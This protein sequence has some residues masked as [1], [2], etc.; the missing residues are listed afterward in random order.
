MIAAYEALW[1]HV[2]AILAQPKYNNTEFIISIG[3]EVDN[4]L[5]APNGSY[6]NDPRGGP[7]QNE[8][9]PAEAW[10]SFGKFYAAVAPYVKANPAAGPTRLVG[11]TLEWLGNDC[12]SGI[13]LLSGSFCSPS[14]T[15]QDVKS[16]LGNSDLYVFT[17]YPGFLVTDNASKVD[18]IVNGDLQNMKTLSTN[19]GKPIVLQEAGTPSNLNNPGGPHTSPDGLL[20]Q[21]QSYFVQSMF[22]DVKAENAKPGG[23]YFQGLN[24]FQLRDFNKHVVAQGLDCTPTSPSPDTCPLGTTCVAS[25]GDQG[26]WTED[27]PAVSPDPRQDSDMVYDAAR[28][29]FVLFGGVQVPPNMPNAAG[30][31]DV[32][33]AVRSIVADP[34]CGPVL[35]AGDNLGYAAE[36]QRLGFGLRSWSSG[37]A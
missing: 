2:A 24:I 12:G 5:N 10:T 35:G 27:F 3:N 19:D 11:V 7:I 31:S 26:T 16:F 8:A 13:S 37:C 25:P 30:F 4:Y 28:S 34:S 29:R 14:L 18:T 9:T 1:D 20:E 32:L 17:Y 22:A 15:V 21:Q 36:R 6:P 23:P 33:G